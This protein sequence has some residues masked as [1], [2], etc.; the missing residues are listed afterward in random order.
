MCADTGALRIRECVRLS[1]VRDP[2]V[3][4][5]DH[6]RVISGSD[7]LRHAVSFSRVCMRPSYGEVPDPSRIAL[8]LVRS[9]PTRRLNAHLINAVNG[10]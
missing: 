4:D 9:A 3:D 5:S 1:V 2:D 7:V 8:S 10:R 6:P